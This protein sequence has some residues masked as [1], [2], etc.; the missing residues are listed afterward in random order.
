MGLVQENG[1]KSKVLTQEVWSTALFCILQL[2]FREQGL[3]KC[4]KKGNRKFPIGMG[5]L[6]KS[7]QSSLHQWVDQATGGAAGHVGLLKEENGG[8]DLASQLR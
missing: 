4:R 5:I 6:F 1:E 3:L 8:N 2:T 7:S